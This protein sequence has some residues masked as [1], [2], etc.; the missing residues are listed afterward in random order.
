MTRTVGGLIVL[1]FMIVA[2]GLSGQTPSCATGVEMFHQ[3]RWSEAA[4]AF[5]LCER[6]EPGKT[7]ALLYRGKS[8]VNLRQFG[9]ATTALENYARAHPQSDDAAYLL[10]YV[11]F[12]QDK[13]RQS[14]ELFSQAAKLKPPSANDL[15]II[16][17]DYVLLND[18]SDAAHYLESS[19]EMNPEDVEARYHLGRVRYQQN[20]FDLAIAAF[21]EVIR[22]DPAN[23][24]AYDNLGLSLEGK[25]EID[26]AVA[27]YRKAIELDQA[28]AS[29]SEQPYLNLGSLLA[30]SNRLEEAIPMLTRA[31]EIAPSQFKVHYELA[32]AYFDSGRLDPACRQAEDAVKLNPRDSSGHYLLGRIYQRLNRKQLAGEQFRLTAA[33]IHD[34][35][36]SQA[37]MASG[38]NSR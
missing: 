27:A 7:D 31:A 32:K 21:K 22:R 33:L 2:A 18:Y 19:L 34:K 1:G 26:A 25:N 9:E 15:M 10:A 17:L 29:H 30:K 36:A 14:L 24:K 6:Q 23:V 13:P 3:K 5:E 8:L 35:N 38:T 37:G 12:R 11:S 20:Q 4:A 28:G 16:A